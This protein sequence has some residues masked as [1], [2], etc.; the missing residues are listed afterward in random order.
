MIVDYKT[1]E[2]FNKFLNKFIEQSICMKEYP[3]DAINGDYHNRYYWCCNCLNME[4]PCMR[5]K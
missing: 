1:G 4:I 2:R 3:V 5:V